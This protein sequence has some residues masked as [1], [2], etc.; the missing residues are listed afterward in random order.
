MHQE[1]SWEG[2]CLTN[3]DKLAL[4]FAL[5]PL[6]KIKANCERI[7]MFTRNLTTSQSKVQKGF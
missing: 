1:E 5:I 3:G 6:G 2:Y 7:E 4:K